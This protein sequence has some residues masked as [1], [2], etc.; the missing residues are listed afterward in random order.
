MQMTNSWRILVADGNPRFHCLCKSTLERAGHEVISA[1]VDA[2]VVELAEESLHLL[3][4]DERG[5]DAYFALAK[6]TLPIIVVGD[7]FKSIKPICS[8]NVFGYFGRSCA[9]DCLVPLV[10]VVM[11]RF[12]EREYLRQNVQTLK[13]SLEERKVIERA[14]GLLMQEQSPDE[15]TAY[16][17]L[18]SV[19]RAQQMKMVDVAK[20]I[21]A[22]RT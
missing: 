5:L 12:T 2:N 9:I 13:Q 8:E 16:N 1:P 18:Q 20:I 11:E 14:K 7:V 6:R 22:T 4:V 3:I 10:S 17:H 15:T 21:I 19:A